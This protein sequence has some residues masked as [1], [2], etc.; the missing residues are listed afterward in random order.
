M[1]TSQ[2]YY[3]STYVF[4]TRS[5]RHLNIDSLDDHR[6]HNLAIAV[7]MIGDDDT[8][9]PPAHALARRGIISNVQGY[10]LYGSFNRPATRHGII[11]RVA[12]GDV[13]VA[14]VW[15][16][17]AGFYAALEPVPLTLT[18]VQPAEDSGARMTFSISI[19]VR[20]GN[21]EL[22]D[23]INNALEQNRSAIR[24][25][26]A[27]YHVPLISDADTSSVLAQSP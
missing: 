27:G 9:T 2:P 25:I 22:K 7:Q 6:L 13:D 17:I 23:R 1:L 10:M 15:G 11:D 8:N 5:D 16:P 19:G 3:T 18:P 14:L 24:N 4:V 20:R 12:A 21:V 26:L